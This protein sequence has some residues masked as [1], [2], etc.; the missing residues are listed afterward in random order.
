M[1]LL[2]C[3]PPWPLIP[4]TW[5]LLTWHDRSI[6]MC[7]ILDRWAVMWHNSN[8]IAN[9]FWSKCLSWLKFE[10]FP[11]IPCLTSN[12]WISGYHPIAS[13]P[14]HLSCGLIE[15]FNKTARM[16]LNTLGW[17]VDLST[18]SAKIRNGSI[19]KNTEKF[20]SRQGWK[21]T[22]S[23]YFE[24]LDC[25]LGKNQLQVWMLQRNEWF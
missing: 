22:K 3:R 14:F 17:P 11:K 23:A 7:T 10:I 13:H 9:K 24:V 1:I 4:V 25:S 8:T 19:L 6:N 12:L 16:L 18:K 20:V 21:M 5:H 2:T 15:N